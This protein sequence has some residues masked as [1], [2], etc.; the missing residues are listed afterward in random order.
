MAE[1]SG[2][3]VPGSHGENSAVLVAERSSFSVKRPLIGRERRGMARE[4]DPNPRMGSKKPRSC[5]VA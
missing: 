4:W 2:E 1:R 3:E 5:A